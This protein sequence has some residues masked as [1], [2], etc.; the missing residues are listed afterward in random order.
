[1]EGKAP[2]P[3]AEERPIECEIHRLDSFPRDSFIERSRMVCSLYRIS[4]KF[5][6]IAHGPESGLYAALSAWRTPTLPVPDHSNI[7]FNVTT[8]PPE[9]MGNKILDERIANRE[10]EGEKKNAE[11]PPGGPSQK[12][13][14]AAVRRARRSGEAVGLSTSITNLYIHTELLMRNSKAPRFYILFLDLF[15]HSTLRPSLIPRFV[16]RTHAGEKEMSDGF[17]TV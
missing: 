14:L 1:M 4:R 6:G 15:L 13:G 5:I 17:P 10:K 3:R 12:F 11:R 16:S 2:A 9:R 7:N 8:F